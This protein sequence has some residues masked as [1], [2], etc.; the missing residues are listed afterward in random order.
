[1]DFVDCDVVEIYL[2]GMGAEGS[3]KVTKKILSYGAISC[4]FEEA[5]KISILAIFRCL[6]IGD[7]LGD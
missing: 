2:L 7:M 3:F 4:L 1:V 5:R 6:G